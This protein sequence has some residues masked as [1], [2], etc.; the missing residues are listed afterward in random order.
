MPI[1]SFADHTVVVVEPG[2]EIVQNSP[3]DDWSETAVTTRELTRCLV[4]P[5]TTDESTSDPDT[6][7]ASYNIKIQPDQTPPSTKAKIRHPL[8]AGDYA[9]IGE[10]M[11][12]PRASGGIDHRA[13]RVERWKNRG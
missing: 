5:A 7:R 2:V 9:V 11:A 10:V 3:D 4:E 6:V 8:A 13:L 1:P 12:V